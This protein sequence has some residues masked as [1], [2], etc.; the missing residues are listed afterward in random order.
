LTSTATVW[1]FGAT[2]ITLNKGTA[3]IVTSVTSGTITFA[4]AGLT[5]NKLTIGGGTNSS[6]FTISGNN[7]FSEIAS[8]RT[9]AYSIILGSGTQRVGAFTAKGT[10]GNLLTIRGSTITSAATLIFTG[11]TYAN[12]NYIVPTFV[13][14]Y[15][16]FS[17]WYAGTN[18]TNSGSYGWIWGAA[19]VVASAINGQ[20]FAFF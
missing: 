3:N 2:G 4:G 1:N 7:T 10:A 16:P 5:Y 17:E 20:F 11:A 14:V 18:S 8:T 13:K 6:T 9:V 19:A 12:L 15:D